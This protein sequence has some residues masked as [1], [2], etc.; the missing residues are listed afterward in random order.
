MRP[1]LPTGGIFGEKSR[2]FCGKNL[3]EKQIK[4]FH[5]NLAL[6]RMEKDRKL[7]RPKRG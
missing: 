3:S 5:K 6:K 7:M 4:N 2:D 1:I